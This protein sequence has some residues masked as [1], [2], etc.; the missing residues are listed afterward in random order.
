M[1]FDT[2]DQVLFGYDFPNTKKIGFGA[3]TFNF[4]VVQGLA[5]LLH[6]TSEVHL[7]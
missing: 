4:F 7:F 5:S 3:Y 2:E 6:G 1:E